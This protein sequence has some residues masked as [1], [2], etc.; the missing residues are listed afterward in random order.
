MNFNSGYIIFQ[1]TD[2][3]RSYIIPNP[4]RTEIQIV[5][6]LTNQII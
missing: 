4:T 6:F 2:I 5:H 1:T 3:R